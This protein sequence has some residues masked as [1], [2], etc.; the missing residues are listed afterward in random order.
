MRRIL[1]FFLLLAL[2]PATISSATTP[3]VDESL[4]YEWRLE[5][6]LGTIARLVF[7]G[8]GV[9]KITAKDIGDGLLET[10]LHISSP[11]SAEGE[12]W[13]YGAEVDPDRGSTREVWS[14]Y[15]HKD[16]EKQKRA[17]VDEDGVIDIASGIYLIRRDPP[18]EPRPMKIWSDGK[19]Y[20][21]RVEPGEWRHRKLAD[22]EKV[23]AR[24]Y[25]I[26]ADDSV[27]SDGQWKG[28]LDIWLADDE[29][30]TPVEI[31]VERLSVRVRMSLAASSEG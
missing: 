17:L 21:V 5:G 30:S 31:L 28:R 27:K 22:G 6:F 24:V 16:K 15:K 13:L 4:A 25:K 12:F 10:E 19:V 3:N 7:P 9:G 2:A 1:T 23:R 11:E 18:T 29:V 26:R 8:R 14:A 20:P